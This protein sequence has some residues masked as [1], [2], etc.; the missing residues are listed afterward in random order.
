MKPLTD[1]D[2]NIAPTEE[3]NLLADLDIPKILNILWRSL[4]WVILIN[5]IMISLA[6]LYLRYTKPIYESS[7]SIKLTIKNEKT[8]QTL[9]NILGIATGGA[10]IA[11]DL[12]LATTTIVIQAIALKNSP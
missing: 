6:W 2:K 11:F 9:G 7:S 1:T 12:T 10:T 4:F 8:A 5:V 3:S